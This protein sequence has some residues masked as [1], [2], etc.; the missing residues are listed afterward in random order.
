MPG[1]LCHL[2]CLG[3]RLFSPVSIGLSLIRVAN[4]Y[5]LYP[6]LNKASVTA[7]LSNLS[8]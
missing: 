6:L 7:V 5:R 4:V 3:T 8:S 1:P 2:P